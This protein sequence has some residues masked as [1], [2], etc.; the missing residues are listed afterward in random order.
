MSAEKMLLY[1]TYTHVMIYLISSSKRDE[2]KRDPWRWSRARPSICPGD[3][4]K[5]SI[6]LFNP[7]TSEGTRADSH[8]RRKSKR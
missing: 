4:K 8:V 1:V 7:V 5:I 2:S 3:P 6:H